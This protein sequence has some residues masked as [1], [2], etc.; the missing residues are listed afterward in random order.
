VAGIGRSVFRSGL[1]KS[2]A[3]IIFLRMLKETDFLAPRPD[4]DLEIFEG[5]SRGLF[6]LWRTRCDFAVGPGMRTSI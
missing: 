6:G 2:L 4:V 1:K 3:A 5:E